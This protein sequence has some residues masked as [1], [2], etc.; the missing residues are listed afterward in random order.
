MIK[1]PISLQDLRRSLYIKAKAE[2]A[3]RF[4]GLYVH[5][6]KT[7]TLYEAYQ[8]AKRNDG[9]PG[10]DGVTFEAIEES[11][12]EGFLKQIQGELVTNTYWPMQARKKEI[13]KDGGNKIRVL[14]IPAIRDRVV[15]GALKLILEPI[16]EA[17]FQSG[18]YGYRPKRT[19]H[20]AVNR[21]AQAIVEEKTR[22]IDVDL[23]SYFDNVQH[24]LLLK[25]VGRRVQ[26]AAVM[27]LLKMILKATGKKGVPQGG[28]VSPLLSNVYLTE[29]DR[30]LEK[31]ITTTRRGKYTH[32]QYARFADDLVILI[33]SHPRQNWLVKA[34]EKR[35]REEVAKLGVEINEEKSRMVDLTKGE[36]FCFLG[37]EY[38]RILSRNKVW[39][40]QYVPRLKKR[41]ALLAKL[42]EIFRR[43]VSQPAERVIELINPILRGWV[44]YFAVGHSSRCFSFIQDWVDK[45]IRRHLMR[46]RQRSG[47]GWN[48]WSRQWLYEKLGLFNQYQLRRLEPL[49]KAQPPGSV[50]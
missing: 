36:S 17:D 24:A 39:R 10:I 6:C 46:A 40:P 32:V 3:W 21:V 45:K 50:S 47:F 23:R 33:D 18:S 15:Q 2:P 28:V 48:R 12:V 8:M 34:V 26:D 31:A 22:V 14:S 1:T 35:L 30:M 29:V 37:F 44:N 38:R 27:H 42:R 43:Y 49:S 5:V 25:K 7:E 41:T 16:F 11:G 20:Q 9:A 13:A 19:A 4:W